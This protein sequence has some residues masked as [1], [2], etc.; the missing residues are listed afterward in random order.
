MM[1]PI[2]AF[3]TLAI[4]PLLPLKRNYCSYVDFNNTKRRLFVKR[5]DAD[6]RMYLLAA[7]GFCFLSAF[8]HISIALLDLVVLHSPRKKKESVFR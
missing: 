2:R 5:M 6:I 8:F 1:T 7:P 3:T 4:Q